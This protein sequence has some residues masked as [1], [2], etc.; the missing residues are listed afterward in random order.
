MRQAEG[1]Y[2]LAQ[3]LGPAGGLAH[4]TNSD[5]QGGGE[6]VLAVLMT[7]LFMQPPAGPLDGFRANFASTRAELDYDFQVGEFHDNDWR[8]W[9]EPLPEFV[10]TRSDDRIVGH[11]ACDGRAEYYLISS[12]PDLLDRARKAVPKRA[13]GKVSYGFSVV[14]KTEFLLD[15]D[16]VCWHQYDPHPSANSSNRNWIAIMAEPIG[17]R[18]RFSNVK[19]PFFWGFGAFPHLLERYRGIVPG[20][21]QIVKSGRPLD[22]EVYKQTSPVN[23]AWTQLELY[24]DPSF[25]FLPRLVRFLEYDPENDRATAMEYFLADARPCASGGFVPYEWY[26]WFRMIDGF[27]KKFK[28]YKFN[29][30]INELPVRDG[31]ARYKAR[32]LKSLAGPVALKEL[33]EVRSIAGLGGVV[34][35]KDK[36]PALTLAEIKTLLGKRLW[37]PPSSGLPKLHYDREEAHRFDEPSGRSGLIIYLAC[38]S[39]VVLGLGGWI[40]RKRAHA[41]KTWTLLIAACLSVCSGC[42]GMRQPVVKLAVHYEKDVVYLKQRASELK[43]RL[44]LRNDGNVPVQIRDVDGGCTCRIVDKAAVPAVIEPGDELGLAVTLKL[45][46]RTGPQGSSYEIK[47]DQGSFRAAAGFISLV[48]HDFEPEYVANTHIVEEEPWSFTFTH[49]A[50]YDEGA[51][52]ADHELRFPTALL[53]SKEH[54]EGG[55]VAGAPGYRYEDTTYRL[56][57]KDR[58]LGDHRDVIRLINAAGETVREASILWKRV[59]FL[60]CV[61]ER[62]ILGTRPV[63]VFLQ[64]PDE[65][66]ELT[67]VVSSPVGIEAV[68]SSPREVTVMLADDPPN[69]INGWVEVYTTAVSRPALRFQVVRYAPLAR[70]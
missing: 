26:N 57:L 9:D 50:I 23:D 3:W 21:Y 36:K 8:P 68:V 24:Y 56:T 13:E 16:T 40:M 1:V 28:K 61:P 42:G 11:W 20:R 15:G 62:V 2:R 46:I 17:E 30:D 29:D 14:P 41:G 69:V 43:L 22:V 4:Q 59:P 48:S 58:S 55:P 27:T 33:S 38:G 54:T 37:M 39:A 6:L 49:R 32:G 19:G 51:I 12:P 35:L 5:L 25:G 47:T 67:K 66:V 10:E 70:R 63:R 53:V 7:C 34:Q 64:C 60:S 52:K 65:S 44:D 45:P 18:P 31:F